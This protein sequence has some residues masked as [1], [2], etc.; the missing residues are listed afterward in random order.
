V[1]VAILHVYIGSAIIEAPIVEGIVYKNVTFIS[2]WAGAETIGEVMV[3]TVTVR[4][5]G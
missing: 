3:V 5:S 2:G 4:G 1:V